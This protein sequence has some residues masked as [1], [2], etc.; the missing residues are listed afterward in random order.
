MNNEDNKYVL[1]QA[2]FW[3]TLFD[4]IHKAGGHFDSKSLVHMTLL[5]FSAIMAQNGIRII[6]DKN[7]TISNIDKI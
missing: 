7:K 6:H 1:C 2:D 3:G 5:E 4:S